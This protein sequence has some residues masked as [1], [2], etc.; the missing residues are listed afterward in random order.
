[1]HKTQSAYSCCC[2]ILNLMKSHCL[3]YRRAFYLDR[4]L[5]CTRTLLW[6]ISGWV[7]RHVIGAM[8]VSL[9]AVAV[10]SHI[11][12]NM[13][14]SLQVNTAA[15]ISWRAFHVCQIILLN[16][17]CICLTVQSFPSQ[18]K[19]CSRTVML[20]PWYS[21]IYTSTAHIHWHFNILF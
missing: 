16:I 7:P 6:A 8:L 12:C 3:L 1:M 4:V 20:I 2:I 18:K 5:N 19:Y 14:D 17:N 15:M 11:T 10:F 21:D 9:P 13:H